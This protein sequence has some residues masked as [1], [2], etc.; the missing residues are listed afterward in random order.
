MRFGEAARAR[1]LTEVLEPE[2]L[3]LLDQQPEDAAT[4][5]QVP[6][7]AM[8]GVVDAGRDEALEPFPPLVEQWERNDHP[9]QVRLKAYLDHVLELLDH[10]NTGD[11]LALSLSVGRREFVPLD[12]DGRDLD[13]YLKP[14][15]RAAST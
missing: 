6:D 15:A 8:R 2:R 4:A 9:A 13:N 1:V 11:E 10:R 14:L 12:S 3:R 5:G 7:P